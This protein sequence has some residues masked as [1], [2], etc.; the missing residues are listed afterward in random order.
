MRKPQVAVEPRKTGWAVQT[1]GTSRADSL[2]E[3]KANAVARGR[4][5]AENKR[6]ELVIKNENGRIAEKASHG[7]DP[8]RSKG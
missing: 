6:T 7:N 5:L 3:L 4:E 2:H 8:R 1:D